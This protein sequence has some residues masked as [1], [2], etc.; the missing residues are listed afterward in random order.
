VTALARLAVFP[1]VMGGAIV[2]M[3]WLLGLGVAPAL[4]LVV[5]DTTALASVVLAE[6][7]LPFRSAWNRDHGD[8]AADAAHAVVSGIGS[9]Q[10]VKPLLDAAG[11]LSAGWIVRTLGAGVWPVGWPLAAQLALAMVVGELGTYWFHRA[12]HRWEPLWRF[13]AVHHSAPRLYWLNAA[14]FHPGDLCLLFAAWYLPLAML[15]C[16]PPVLALAAMFDAVLGL[17]QHSNVDVRLGPLN[18]VFSMAEPHRWHHSRTLAEAN[19]N[20]GSNLS[21]WDVVFGTYHLPADRLP[22]ADIGIADMPHFPAGWSAHIAAPF[23]WARVQ[24]D[25]APR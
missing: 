1:V 21:V 13:H 22:P 18:R 14:R 11:V 12:Q 10:A 3:L 4:A 16:P 20:F 19:T 23:R 24:A 2:F 25:S 7:L 6:R 15:G 9:Q 8:F 5:A 17:L